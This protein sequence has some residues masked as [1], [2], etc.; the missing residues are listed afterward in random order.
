MLQHKPR[1]CASTYEAVK[2]KLVLQPLIVTQAHHYGYTLAG[3]FHMRWI[4][5]QKVPAHIIKR[6]KWKEKNA[7]GKKNKK[8]CYVSV[9]FLFVLNRGWLTR[10]NALCSYT[11][12]CTSWDCVPQS[13]NIQ[14]WIICWF[15]DECCII[16]MMF[17]RNKE[18]HINKLIISPPTWLFSLYHMWKWVVICKSHF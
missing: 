3:S 7:S 2:Q 6:L 4:F 1:N 5:V 11:F 8:K 14:F 15:M 17:I 16:F 12:Y 18:K 13:E 10:F 9:R